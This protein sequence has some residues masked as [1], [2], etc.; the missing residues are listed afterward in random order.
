V[1]PPWLARPIRGRAQAMAD[2][3]WVD[4]VASGPRPL[5]TTDF[6]YVIA[7]TST[8][9][10]LDWSRPTERR[11]RTLMSANEAGAIAAS[12]EELF[13]RSN[14]LTNSYASARPSE[15]AIVW[16]NFHLRF[17]S[18]KPAWLAVNADVASACG[19]LPTDEFG[20]WNGRDGHARVRSAIWMDGVTDS[21]SPE[22]YDE[23]GHGAYVEATTEAVAE[24]EATLGP[25]LAVESVERDA[26]P[27]RRSIRKSARHFWDW[28]SLV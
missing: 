12:D 24:L 20:I 23:P 14:R 6:G 3:Q 4:N 16:R 18:T 10:S 8:V 13:G 5:P 17:G 27:D 19:W 26:R 9:R 11:R 7:E 28:R 2:E 25:L 22:L 15:P 1:A 21:P